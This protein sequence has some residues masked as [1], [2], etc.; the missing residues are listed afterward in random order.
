MQPIQEAVDYIA[1]CCPNIGA[2]AGSTDV[3]GFLKQTASDMATTQPSPVF[4]ERYIEHVAYAVDLVASNRFTSPPAAIASVYLATRFEFYFRILSGKLN[5]DGK[6][7]TSDA[8]RTARAAIDDPRIDRKRVSSVALTYKI[9]KL[10]QSCVLAQYCTQLD[11]SL[12]ETP[13][14]VTG[15]VEVRDI[16]DRIKFGRNAAGHGQWGDISAEAP[17]YGLLTAIVF[18]SQIHDVL[19]SKTNCQAV[20]GTRRN[21]RPRDTSENDHEMIETWQLWRPGL[22]H[23]EIK[24]IRPLLASWEKK[25]HPAQLHLAEYLEDVTSTLGPLPESGDLFLDLAVDVGEYE[26]LQ[27]HYDV[28]NYLTPLFGSRY[29]DHHRFVLVSGSKHIGGGSRIAVGFATDALPNKASSD[30]EFF[31]TN[32]GSGAS[33]HQWKQGLRADLLEHNPARLPPGPVDVQIAWRC[34]SQRNWVSLWKPT[35][36]A[37]GPVLGEDSGNPFNPNDDRIVS[38]TLHRIVD[39]TLGNNIEVGMW[40]RSHFEGD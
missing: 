33:T 9:M 35:G 19:N 14:T 40:W 37:M 1:T 17:F 10:D 36:D 30:W 24:G 25:T 39:E 32:A 15:G 22:V 31:S 18:Y 8:Q 26:R 23:R 11:R 5:T 4:P 29:L 34:S 38:L 7:L 16:G 3:F 12:Y 28:E 27:R 2:Y 20:Y 21:I 13:T 6:W